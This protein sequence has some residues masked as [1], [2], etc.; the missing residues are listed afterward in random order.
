MVEGGKMHL[1]TW[2]IA[3]VLGL[4][5]LLAWTLVDTSLR[6]QANTLD[7]IQLQVE[8]TIDLIVDQQAWCREDDMPFN[9]LP[10]FKLKL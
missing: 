1:V 10:E 2:A 5:G 7:L 8:T 4:G 9:I 3:V 6:E